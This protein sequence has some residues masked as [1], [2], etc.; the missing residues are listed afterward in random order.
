MPPAA[1]VIHSLDTPLEACV[2]EGQNQPKLQKLNFC[3][4]NEK[5]RRLQVEL[6]LHPLLITCAPAA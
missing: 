5:A 3:C 1:S 2:M 6:S 4:E